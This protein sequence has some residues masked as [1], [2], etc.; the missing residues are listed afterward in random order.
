MSRVVPEFASVHISEEELLDG[1]SASSI[2][3]GQS[4]TQGI[5][6]DDLIALPGSI[7]K[8]HSFT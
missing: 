8:I 2:F 6:F 5:T 1:Y 4:D 3:E 7:G